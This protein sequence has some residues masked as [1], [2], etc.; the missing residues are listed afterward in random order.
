M[1]TMAPDHPALALQPHS[2][3]LS[4]LRS[5]GP[6]AC[7][8][9]LTPGP[10]APAQARRQVRAAIAAW[11]VP[12]DADIAVLLTSDLVTHAFRHAWGGAVTLGVRRT[13]TRLRVDVHWDAH[14]A[15]GIH[16]VHGAPA[17]GLVLVASLSADWGCYQAQSGEAAYFTLALDA[18]GEFGPT[19]DAGR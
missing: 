16:G 14:G 17:P 8:V 18:G 7:R 3:L 5:A 2:S 19:A 10:I 1:H 12:V 4:Q 13:R 11:D 9:R 6:Q 15:Q